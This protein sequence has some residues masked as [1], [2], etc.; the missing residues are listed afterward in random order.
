MSF[1]DDYQA[2]AASGTDSPPEFHEFM[3]L[4]TAGV[5]IG[6][7]RWFQLGHISIYPNIYMIVLAPSSLYRKS[8]ILS[9]SKNMLEK[10]SPAKSYPSDFSQEKIMQI[11]HENPTGIFYYSEFRSLMEM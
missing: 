11:I 8:T 10:V 5:M 7:T 6:R 2:Y 3:A 9:I 4:V 1:L